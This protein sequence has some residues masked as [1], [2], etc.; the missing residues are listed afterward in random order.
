MYVTQYKYVCHAIQVCMSRNAVC[1]SYHTIMY[2]TQ[3]MSRNTVGIT[4]ISYFCHVSDFLLAHGMLMAV[5]L[6]LRIC[7]HG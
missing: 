3:H 5:V 6:V 1:M 7:H 4:T 2:F